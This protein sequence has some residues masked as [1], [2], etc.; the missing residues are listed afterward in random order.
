[1]PELPEVE[2]VMRGLQQRLEGR[3]IVRAVANRP[4][5][6]WPLPEGLEQRLTGARVE[7]FRRRGKY[8]L[9]RLAGGDSTE[10]RQAIRALLAASGREDVYR[11][12]AIVGTL[13]QALVLKIC[14]VLVHC[15]EGAETQTAG[16]LLIGRGVAVFL[17]EAGEKVDDLFLPSRNCH[18]H[19]CSE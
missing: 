14:D 8:I 16:D 15:G 3:L 19:D 18:A 13:K 5:L 4:D 12:A 1:M 10:K 7:N 6:R 17:G 9:M 2:T 11:T